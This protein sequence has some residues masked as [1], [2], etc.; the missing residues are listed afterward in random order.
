MLK[1][2]VDHNGANDASRSCL[3]KLGLAV[4]ALVGIFFLD[5]PAGCGRMPTK[6]ELRNEHG[7]PAPGNA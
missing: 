4:A 2:L 7:E 1:A 3:R 5:A 6:S